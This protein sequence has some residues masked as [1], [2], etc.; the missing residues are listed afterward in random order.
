MVR[1][2]AA[3]Q[4]PRAVFAR[5]QHRHAM[6]RVERAL[7]YQRF[8]SALLLGH[9]AGLLEALAKGPRTAAE[10][11]AT[12]KIRPAAADTLLRV[13]ESEGLLTRAGERWE[14]TPASQRYLTRAG[15][16]SLSDSLDLMAAQAAAFPSILE[17]LRTGQTPAALDVFTEGGRYRAFLGAVNAFLD[18]AGRDLLGRIELPPIGSLLVGSMGVSFSA[19]VL[20]RYPAARVTYGCLAHLVR[21]IPALRVRYGVPEARVTGTHAHGGDPETD[22][23][24]DER[25]DLVFLTKKMIL[26]PDRSLGARFAAKA[27]QVLRPDGAV[28]LWE[29]VHGGAAPTPLP[30][31]MEAV[32][33]L[34]VSPGAPAQ[35]EAGLRA[36]L[37]GIGFDRIQMVP[38]LGGRT[39]FVVA[40]RPA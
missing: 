3:A 9:D 31:A 28:I 13:L 35:T 10:V 38:C 26:D 4:G 6:A 8:A 16:G 34:G 29:T 11:A 20:A 17:G 2:A 18:V 23:W 30:L 19:L 7:F 22:R 33:D 12:C 40:R 25:F 1:A 15:A 36:L 5:W 24:G 32:L 21:E 27:F 37:G 14:L 39:S